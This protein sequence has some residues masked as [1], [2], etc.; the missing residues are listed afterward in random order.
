MSDATDNDL[1]VESAERVF[2]DRCTPE[3]LAAAEADGWAPGVWSAVAEMGLPWISVPEEAGGSGGSLGDALAVLR[4]AGYHAAP[5]PLAETGMLGGWLLAEAGL[6]VG[7]GPLTVVPGRPEDTVRLSGGSLSGTAHGVAWAA[8]AERIVAVLDGTV[9]TVAPSAGTVTTLANMAGEPRSSITFDGAAVTE[10]GAAPAG[11][12]AEALRYRGAL[13]RVMLMAG[14]LQA[15]S[16]VTNQYAWERKQFGQAIGSFQAVQAHLVSAAEEAAV[17]MIAA[18]TA[19]RAAETGPARFEIAAAKTLASTAVKNATK[20]VHQAHGA[21]GMTQEYR[22]H[23]L[24]RRL[25]AWRSEYGDKQWPAAVGAMAAG[26]GPDRLY[27]LIQHGSAA[28]AT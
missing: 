24:T 25:W 15:I 18:E 4:I 12:D 19:A 27:S 22:L 20:A 26:L 2:T 23:H 13:S 7:E 10:Q 11:V 28:L 8:Q 9:V 17:V 5:V 16:H 21:I 6:P 14:A 3:A 1:L